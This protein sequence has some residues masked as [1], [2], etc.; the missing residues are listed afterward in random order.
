MG[1]GKTTILN[2][3]QS[4]FHSLG[5]DVQ[6]ANEVHGGDINKAYCLYTRTHKYFLKINNAHRYPNM[7][8]KEAEGLNLLRMYSDLVVPEVITHGTMGS[9]QYLI[10]EWIEKGQPQKDCAIQFGQ[11][12]AQMHRTQQK[13][14]GL[15]DDNYIG[16]IIQKNTKHDNWSSFYSEC[17]ILPLVKT[18]YNQKYFSSSDVK[19]AERLCDLLP[20]IFPDE[21]PAL[22]HGDLWKGNYCI[23]TNGY[24]A[25][26]DP[27]VYNGHRE[28][29]IGMTLL[30]GGF[31]KVFYEAYNEAY[32][33]EKDWEKRVPYTQLYPYLVHAIL[34]KGYYMNAVKQVLDR[35]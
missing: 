10:L 31:E 26:Y 22:L 25:I 1:F 8:V 9:Y 7:F 15:S 30:F 23:N 12:L 2:T 20:H 11:K 18:L 17:R 14:F 3:L 24:A 16:S 27:A 32:P 19:K 33:L 28:M 5:I 21:S 35:F 4:I 34:F 6:Y 13:Y 29:D